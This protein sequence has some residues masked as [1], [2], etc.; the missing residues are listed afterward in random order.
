MGGR[1]SGRHWRYDAKDTVEDY[2]SID[3]RRWQRDGLLIPGNWFRWNWS[4]DGQTVASINVR[5]QNAAVVL[6]YRHRRSGEEWQSMEY[7]VR[8]DQTPC[9]YGGTR[10]WFTCPVAGCGRRVAILY[11]G[12]R[13]F[14]CRNC[15]KLVYESQREAEYYRELR[16]AQKIRRKLGGSE[17]TFDPFPQKP[18]GMHWR[19]YMRLSAVAEGAA[20]ASLSGVLKTLG[21]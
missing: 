14:A 11:M 1:G 21:C 4:R 5:V 15:Y 9:T 8:L 10:R 13:Y 3:V 17:S 19:T 16:K 2:R 18:K 7:L 12:G 6:E 20:A